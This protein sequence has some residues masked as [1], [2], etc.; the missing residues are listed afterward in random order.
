MRSAGLVL[1]GIVALLAACGAQAGNADLN[2]F[3]RVTLEFP[4]DQGRADFIDA[5]VESIIARAPAVTLWSHPTAAKAYVFAERDVCP[6]S[7]LDDVLGLPGTDAVAT[8]R[9]TVTQSALTGMI[10]AEDRGPSW[11][12]DS[13]RQCVLRGRQVR[14]E[15]WGFMRSLMGSGLRDPSVH[16][17][18]E[19]IFFSANESCTLVE[20]VAQAAMLQTN[21]G[22]VDLRF[23]ANS[24]HRACGDPME[25]GTLRAP[26]N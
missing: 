8:S 26:I 13:V 17:N 21:G 4:S 10:A 24:S 9:E 12:Q 15:P 20:R 23:C 11:N 18:G 3:C 16:G 25:F 22:V 19:S 6:A 7:A 5:N 2:Q 1:V 14:D